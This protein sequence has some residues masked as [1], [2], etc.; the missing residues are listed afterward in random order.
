MMNLRFL[1]LPLPANEKGQ[2]VVIVAL[3]M[4]FVF[5]AFAAL[6][7]DGTIIYLHRREL[8]N[9]ADAA[10]LAA[11]IELNQNKTETEAYQA[12]INSITS[13]EGRV[14][15]YSTNAS[16]NPPGTNIG[17]GKDLVLGIEISNRCDVR[18]AL[19]WSDVGTYF[20]QF[21]G[22]GNLEVGAKARAGCNLAG[23]LQPIAV[24]RFGDQF[25]WDTS[26]GLNTNNATVYCDGCN[27]QHS[28]QGPPA[29]GKGNANDFLRPEAGDAD[30]ISEWPGWPDGSIL[31]QS[32]SPHADLA[33]GTPGREFFFLG[34]GVDPNQGT[35]SYAG[36]INLDIRHISAPPVEYYNG[37]TAGTNSNTLKDLGEYYIRRGYC[38]DIP[39]PGDQVS[40][41]NG[42][43][44]AFAAQAF[45][46]TYAVGDVVAVIIYNGTVFNTPNLV[47]TGNDPNYNSPPTYP[48]TTTLTS[49][50]VTYTVELEAELGFQ[51]AP[52]GLTMDVEGLSGLADW[53]FSPTASPVLGHSGINQRTIQ[54]TVVPTVTTVGTTTQ[55]LT[56]TWMFYISAIDDK[57]GGTD[58]RRYWPG[59]VSIGDEVD[60]VQR[61]LP[62]VTGYPD[63]IFLSVIKG[64]PATTIRLNLDVWGVTADQNVTVSSGALPTGFEWAN[65]QPP[66]TKTVD[67]DDHPGSGFNIKL[68]VND[69][70]VSQ[71]TPY[72][73]PLTVSAAGMTPQTFNIYVIVEDANTTIKDYVEILGYA[74]LE[75]TGYY[76]SSNLI[77]PTDPSPPP[78]NAVRGRIVSEMWDHPSKMTYGLRARLV[79]WD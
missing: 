26:T 55:V 15:W 72:A 7:I 63:P 45:Q 27:T 17:A 36:L 18:V 61:Q 31:Y 25:D 6:S 40:M 1:R 65:P 51:S 52:G 32:P 62:S 73:I 12:A 5:L 28:I 42:N 11:A 66:W 21:V 70:A 23:G 48:T 8:Q 30:V 69:T 16:P 24:K 10:A 64:D 29:Q 22:R 37:V 13:N 20:A 41:Y 50:A 76:N 77:D 9:I 54:M 47:I 79:P 59:I 35:A 34:G 3:F 68:R 4:F 39:A 60:G 74:A 53:S 43:S 14:E 49:H 78:A 71:P 19:R 2:S 56:G 46:E 58:I 57:L 67:W 75:I 33:G 44:T 38:C